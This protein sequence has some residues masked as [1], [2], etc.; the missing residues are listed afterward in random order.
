MA[1][2]DLRVTASTLLVV[3]GFT[4][5][6]PGL[7]FVASTVRRRDTHGARGGR[8]ATIGSWLVLVGS[9]GFSVLAS[10]D[11]VTLAATHVPDRA[12]MTEYLHRLDVSPGVLA[13]TAPALVGYFVGPFL[14]TLAARR[15]GI[16]PKWLPAAVLASLILQPVGAGLGGPPVA[17]VADLVLQLGLVVTLVLLA[18]E[19]VAAASGATGS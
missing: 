9:V 13:I 11:L 16:G 3:T 8:L 5:I 19:V 15:A 10:V 6:V 2:Q 17:S 4:A 7:W 12:S 14:V 1:G 18:R